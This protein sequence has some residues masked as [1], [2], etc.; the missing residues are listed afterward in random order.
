[1]STN[2]RK[3][4]TNSLKRDVGPHSHTKKIGIKRKHILSLQPFLESIFPEKY[5]RPFSTDQQRFLS[6]IQNTILNGGQYAV[7][8]PRGEGKTTIITGAIVWAICYG[9]R[10]Y[11]V[12]IGSD[13]AAA[14]SILD[15]VKITMET[16]DNLNELFPEVCHYI[17]ALEGLSQRAKGQLCNGAPTHI[18]W[19]TDAISM[20]FVEMDEKY[21]EFAKGAVICARGLTGRLRGLQVTQPDG[22]VVRPDFVFLDDPQ[23]RES[24]L[25]ASQCNDRENLINADV[26]GLAGVGTELACLM[27]CTVISQGD[28]AERI[29][30]SWRAMRAKALYQ[31]PKGHNTLWAEYIELRRQARKEGT[32]KIVCN[33]FYK[34]NRDAMDEG[35][36]VANEY[37]KNK[38]ELSALQ[39]VYNYI[40]DNGF[41]SFWSELQN[42][43]QSA[44][45]KFYI[46]T[47]EIV[48]SRVNGNE[49]NI[50]PA[51]CHYVNLG[52]DV[53]HY[54]LNWAVSAIQ[55]DMTGNGIDYGRYPKGRVLWAD[56]SGITA[57][58]AI[59]DG[60]SELAKSMMQRQPGIKLIGI[61]G[62]Y[63]TDT[64]YR[65]ADYLNKTLPCRVL[66]FR[67]VGSDKYS[68]PM[69]SKTVIRKGHECH[70]ATGARG[71]HVIFNSHYW[72]SFLQKSFLLTPGFRGSYSFWGGNDA[73]HRTIADHIIADKLIDLEYKQG[74]E[75][76]TWTKRPGERN[77]LADALCI[78]LVGA[79]IFGAE[80]SGSQEIEQAP[81]SQVNNTNT[82]VRFIQI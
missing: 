73:D 37:R 67:G 72:H 17:R 50:I 75:I 63:S 76:Y 47:S 69:N 55:N 58:Q 41:D 82:E 23:T 16:S 61:D 77:D 2:E 71:E 8:M 27:A 80:V 26:M 19:R 54:A 40:S 48:K 44:A 68:L 33:N 12:I 39:N 60:L 57:E 38:G 9:H 30:N 13:Q 14:E 24:A 74:K 66:V 15:G 10:K 28:L 79:A 81:V 22:K 43:P 78:S 53:N 62:N 25:S 36:I 51:D 46:I 34:L 3:R 1:M 11:P 35:A 32:E 18:G 65:V 49:R 5:P 59:Y 6:E 4:V 70:Y 7:A 52:I 31:L 42:D 29:L 56:D 64:V 21:L 20:P 45:S